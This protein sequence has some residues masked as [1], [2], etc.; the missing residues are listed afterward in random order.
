MIGPSLGVG[1]ERV[2]PHEG[3]NLN[4]SALA[5]NHLQDGVD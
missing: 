3:R 1:G 2:A 4:G 5:V